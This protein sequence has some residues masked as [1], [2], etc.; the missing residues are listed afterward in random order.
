M[1]DARR[2]ALRTPPPALS[3]ALRRLVSAVDK[4]R[5]AF[6]FLSDGVVRQQPAPCREPIDRS[7][8]RYLGIYPQAWKGIKPQAWGGMNPQACRG[9]DPAVVV[10]VGRGLVPR[11]P[12]GWAE[13]E[14]D[15]R[16]PVG[17]SDG[18][19]GNAGEQALRFFAS[20]RLEL[21]RMDWIRRGRETVGCRSVARVVKNKLAPPDREAEVELLF[22]RFP[23]GAPNLQ[24]WT[25]G[26][27]TS[28]GD[29]L[30]GVGSV[31]ASPP[32]LTTLPRARPLPD[33]PP[34]Q[35]VAS[36]R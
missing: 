1:L 16:R 23:P 5:V 27:S 35:I 13:G 33:A 30:E 36:R 22:Y 20:V 6:V 34:A 11:R 26:Q 29:G 3:L 17:P 19:W 10:D 14:I 8:V 15:P 24:L 7:V 2:S 21:E 9:I 12:E 25:Q 31:G 18:P 4:N 32:A 28:R